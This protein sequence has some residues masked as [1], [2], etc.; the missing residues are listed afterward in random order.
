MNHFRS[1]TSL[2]ITS[3][4]FAWPK[5]NPIKAPFDFVL[6][7]LKHAVALRSD[8][9]ARMGFGS[10]ACENEDGKKG[11]VLMSWPSDLTYRKRRQVKDHKYENKFR[12]GVK[13]LCVCVS[14]VCK[15]LFRFIIPV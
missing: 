8:L 13:E 7:S 1:I 9:V 15:A 2:H 4:H 3:I 5:T 12:E 11:L 10:N 6:R 14:V